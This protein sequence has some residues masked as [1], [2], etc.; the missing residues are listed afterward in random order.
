MPNVIL[1]HILLGFTRIY[2]VSY[3][4]FAQ[5]VL[6][7]TP[8]TPQAYF[9]GFLLSFTVHTPSLPNKAINTASAT[10]VD[11]TKTIHLGLLIKKKTQKKRI[12]D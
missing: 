11:T 3:Y 10:L 4:K 5:P 12:V 9:P 7:L 2:A 1:L 6:P 8:A